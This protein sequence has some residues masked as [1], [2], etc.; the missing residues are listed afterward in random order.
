MTKFDNSKEFDVITAIN[1][2]IKL[3][4]MYGWTGD[5]FQQEVTYCWQDEMFEQECDDRDKDM[6]KVYELSN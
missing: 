5:R 2:A 3:A 1:D 4:I 6:K